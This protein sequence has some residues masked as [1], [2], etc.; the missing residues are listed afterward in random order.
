M[1]KKPPPWLR[2]TK[3]EVEFGKST[4]MLVV[5]RPKTRSDCVFGGWNCE[6][7]CPFVGCQYHTMLT[8]TDCGSVKMNYELE[9]IHQHKTCLLDM[10]ATG[11]Q[12]L[13]D[14]GRELGLTRA[15]VQQIEKDSL[16]K[17]AHD[18]GIRL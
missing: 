4:A 2:L 7:P 16:N 10:T 14:I 8:V 6:R 15:R 5:D 9:D 13:E 18:I 17:L 1:K 12:T 3:E 11:D